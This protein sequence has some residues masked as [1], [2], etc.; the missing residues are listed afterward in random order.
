MPLTPLD[1]DS[2]DARSRHLLVLPADVAPDEVETLAVSRFPRAEWEVEPISA[3]SRGGGVFGGRSTPGA[4]G[5]LRL[6]RHSTLNG[7]FGLDDGAAAALGLPAAATIA[8][9][10]H[11]PVERGPEPWAVGGDRDG[12][13]RA[14][15]DGLPVRDEERTVSWLVAAARRLGGAVRIA[16]R[17]AAEA[18]AVLVPDPAAAVDLTVWSDIWLEPDAALAVMRQAVPRA[19]LNLPSASWEGPPRGTGERPVPGAEDLDEERRRALHAVADERDIAT[20]TDPPPMHG[21]G[22][23]VDLQLDGMIALEVSGETLLPPVIAAVPWASQ[24]AVAYRVRWEP[25]DLEQREAER[26]SLQHR[27]ERGRAAPLVIAITRAVHQAV[28]GEITDMM[29]FVVDPAD[30]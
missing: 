23:L 24:G 20:L 5:V 17:D 26:P 3:A 2:P 1:P 18:A 29:D 27:V 16:P 12:L 21:Y 9:V 11:A 22:A 13:R 8:Y 6:S 10:S 30:L 4:P 7:P 28:G 14:F 25:A 15:P 19:Y